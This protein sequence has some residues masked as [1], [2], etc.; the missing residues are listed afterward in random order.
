MSLF[1]ISCAR[2]RTLYV[3]FKASINVIKD[4]GQS[5]IVAVFR[6]V[7][8]HH[9]FIRANRPFSRPEKQLLLITHN[10]ATFLKMQEVYLELKD[11]GVLGPGQIFFQQRIHLHAERSRYNQHVKISKKKHA[12][13]EPQSVGIGLRFT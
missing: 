3:A 8:E 13:L 1:S 6:A 9:A 7:A 12:G 2:Y 11:E 4:I 10:S 5:R